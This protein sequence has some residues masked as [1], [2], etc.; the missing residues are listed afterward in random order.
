MSYTGFNSKTAE[1]LLLDAG[2]F[3]LNVDMTDPDP[4]STGVLIGATRDGGE[5]TATPE[6]RMIPIDGIK[7]RA[8]GL[9]VIDSWEVMIKANLLE[10][11]SDSLK[12]A[13][14]SAKKTTGTGVLEGYDIIEANNKISLIDYIDNVTWVG[15]LSGI[16]NRPVIIQVFNALN[17][18][19][20]TL[21]TKDKDEA[22]I[23]LEF[24][25]HYDT[26]SLQT[27]PF[28]KFFPVIS[29]IALAT[30]SLGTIN[31]EVGEIT[32]I[33]NGTTLAQFKT[34]LTLSKFA[35]SEVYEA[36]GITVATVLASTNKLIVT[37]EDGI[38]TKTYTLTVL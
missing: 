34:V 30:A 19:G 17:T 11:T 12:I 32:A 4:L 8:K 28:K 22:V 26:T 35:T 7:G 6:I 3:Y 25:G 18:T 33:P 29:T 31:N 15:T 20:L 14:T 24:V 21:S 13:L 27:P 1:R 9:S 5:F 23:S 38:T 36:D 2:A 16:D 10:I 37:A